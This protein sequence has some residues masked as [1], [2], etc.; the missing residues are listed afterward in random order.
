MVGGFEGLQFKTLLNCKPAGG[1]AAKRLSDDLE[2]KVS[3]IGSHGPVNNCFT[4]FF[5]N[6]NPE[7]L[8]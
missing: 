4:D 2:F 3:F 1:K 5:N 7:S 8:H 6:G